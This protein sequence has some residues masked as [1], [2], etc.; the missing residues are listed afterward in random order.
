MSYYTTSTHLP[1]VYRDFQNYQGQPK[2]AVE[3]LTRIYYAPLPL[4]VVIVMD[5]HKNH[6]HRSQNIN[7]QLV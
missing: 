4:R 6:D 3:S 2:S 1:A 7:D 5:T